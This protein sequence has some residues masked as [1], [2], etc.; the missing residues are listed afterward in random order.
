MGLL[1]VKSAEILE[2]LNQHRIY[3]DPI[4]RVNW[5]R[6]NL[7]D[8]WLPEEAL[9]LYGITE[10]MALSP[11]QRK[12]LSHF[13]YLHFLEA[14]IWLEGLFMERL[15]LSASYAR[16]NI[17]LLKYH[18]N[19]LRE[20]A[21]HSLV[22]A[23]I[24]Q[25]SGLPRVATRFHDLGWMNWFARHSSVD[26]VTFWLTAMLSQEIP[27]RINRVI[28][29]NKN[30]ICPAIFDVATFH[31]V[32]EVRHI[33]FSRRMVDAGVKELSSGRAFVIRFILQRMLNQFADAYFYPEPGLYDFAG[34][35]PGRSWA[36]LARKNPHRIQFI[37][38][39]LAGVLHNLQ[40]VGVPLT[41]RPR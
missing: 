19:E 21:G 15:S 24:I 26:S 34:L 40:Q 10:F 17:A 20:Q 32:D 18:L 25:R 31:T 23:E 8:Y 4:N 35:V 3:Q 13:E 14:Q 1:S 5:L 6:L 41:W 38:Q 36:S 39:H 27:D 30:T 9:S 29:Q 7:D 11:E 37:R 16:K 12:A 22:F 33:S 28:R 2:R